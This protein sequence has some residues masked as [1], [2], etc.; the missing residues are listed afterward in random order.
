MPK[1]FAR[2]SRSRARRGWRDRLRAI[3]GACYPL[4]FERSLIL[5]VLLTGLS[6]LLEFWALVGA[7][8]SRAESP[9]ALPRARRHVGAILIGL[10]P[11]ALIITALVRNSQESV[12][13]TN[14]L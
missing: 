6:I 4:G 14:E 2:G 1:V 8:N 3:L 11:L 12:G 13:S 9:A 10:P 7:A 5:D